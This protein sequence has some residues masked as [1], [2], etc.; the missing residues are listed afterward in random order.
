MIRP[1]SPL[2]ML[3]SRHTRPLDLRPRSRRPVAAPIPPPTPAADLFGCRPNDIRWPRSRPRRIPRLSS[4]GGI[5]ARGK[6]LAKKGGGTRSPAL[7]V[8]A[9]APPTA[10]RQP[11]RRASLRIFV[12]QC[13]LPCDPPVGGHSCNGGMI[14]RLS[15]G[16]NNAFC[17]AKSL[18]R[19]CLRMGWSGRAPT[20]PASQTGEG[21]RRQRSTPMSEKLNSKIAVIGIDI[22][23]NSFHIVGQDS[24]GA[25]VLRQKWSRGQVEARLANLPP[26]LIGMEA[27]TGAHHLSRKLQ[28]LGHDAEGVASIG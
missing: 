24:R 9:R 3:L 1:S 11:R 19:P 6:R 10:T 5:H 23:K 8:A 12:V 13:G 25:L 15:E 17:A 22:G 7:P 20:L 21:H 2:T 27:C 26:C 4:P 18:S 14:P 16:T 28:A